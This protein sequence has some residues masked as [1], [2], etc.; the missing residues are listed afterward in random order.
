[1]NLQLS[2]R[3]LVAEFQFGYKDLGG[4]IICKLVESH[5]LHFNKMGWLGCSPVLEHFVMFWLVLTHPSS[6]SCIVCIVIF[7]TV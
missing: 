7:L 3:D 5:G 2:S 1:M 4:C 6:K